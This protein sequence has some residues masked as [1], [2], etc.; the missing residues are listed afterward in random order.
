[1][2][3]HCVD[4]ECRRITREDLGPDLPLYQGVNLMIFDAQYTLLET[5]EKVNWGHAAAGLGLDL[6]MREGIERVLFMHHDPASSDEKIATVEASTRRYYENALRFAREGG[7]KL[8][9]VQWEFAR[10]G[11]VLEV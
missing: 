11:S 3:A 8:H 4:T 7:E 10:E 6:A 9:A 5:I 1:M 2:Y